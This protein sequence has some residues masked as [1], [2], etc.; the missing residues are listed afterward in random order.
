MVKL[1]TLNRM[2]MVRFHSGLC[3]LEDD[4]QLVM[5]DSCY[6]LRKACKFNSYIVRFANS[7]CDGMVDVQCSSYCGFKAIRVQVPSLVYLIA[8]AI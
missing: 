5:E 6:L 2:I 8:P 1:S 3:L 4:L 7:E